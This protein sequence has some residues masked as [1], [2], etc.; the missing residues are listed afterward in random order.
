MARTKMAITNQSLEKV[1]DGGNLSAKE[2]ERA[3]TNVFLN[4]KEGYHH[5]AL[6]ASLHAKGET[7][8]E[9][10]G[11]CRST[12]KLGN[13]LTP[14]VPARE[15]TDLSG[16]GGG[17]IKTINVS[18]AASFIVAGAGY[19][20]AKQAI[21]GITS[22]TGSADVFSAFGIDTYKLGLN[23]VNQTL[24]KV[25]IC[26]FYIAPLSPKLKNRSVLSKKVFVEKGI[27]IKTPLH[28]AAFAYSPTSLKR[29]IYGC[30]SE[31]YLEVLG[32]LFSEL[33]NEKTLVLYGADGIPEASNVG[34]T[35]VVEQAGKNIK[36]YILT[37]KDFGLKK[38]RVDEIRTGG[39]ERN[40]ID[41]LRVLSSKEKGAKR[42]L[43]IAN[44]SA[45]L[46]AMGEVNNF[47]E[48]TMQAEQILDKGMAFKKLEELIK[49]LGSKKQ[50]ENWKRKAG[51]L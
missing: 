9:L 19:T 26:P 8:D 40:I 25:G 35:V 23:Q 45:S 31:K 22:P 16:T 34:K 20:V 14:K 21:F 2:A 32:K 29:R 13:K 15:I 37:P 4:D 17:K 39:K 6:C 27:S 42:D 41:F 18:T 33:G 24:E 28:I 44:A 12:A 1:V 47:K 5:L 38:S 49:E 30:Y 11:L 43:V 10:L 51:V 36:K 7:L 50:F 48:G 3:F 46:Y